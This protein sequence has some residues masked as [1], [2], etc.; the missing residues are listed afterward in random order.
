MGAGARIGAGLALVFALGRVTAGCGD[1]AF[2]CESDAS[3]AGLAEAMCEADGYCS[4]PDGE[5]NSGR[6]YA[7]HSGPL[8]DRCVAE[9]EESGGGSSGATAA[10]EGIESLDGDGSTSASPM[11]GDATGV[12]PTGG[13]DP[14]VLCEGEVFVDDPF[15]APQLD[16]GPWD[17]KDDLGVWFELVDGE[18]RFIAEDADNDYTHIES[19][20][21]LPQAGRA[22]VE[23][24]TAPPPDLSQGLAYFVLEEE[25]TTYGFQ[26]GQG[27]LE[28]FYDDGFDHTSIAL[29]SHDPLEHRWLQLV[30]DE[31]ANWLAWESSADASRW[32]RLGEITIELGFQIG[33]ATIDIG[34]G[35]WGGPIS[36]DP[37]AAYGRAYVCAP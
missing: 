10:S 3:C 2:T 19:G 32:Q 6:R 21:K 34:A 16:S 24:V 7:P 13:V 20:F 17:V 27:Q 28:A 30:F 35:A 11:T 8:S 12:E 4:V 1:S 22:G 9:A 33:D 15:D 29:L 25:G 5:C 37:L 23:L 26:V 14:V 31:D 18:L 36:A